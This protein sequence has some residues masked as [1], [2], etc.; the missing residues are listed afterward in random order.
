MYFYYITYLSGYVAYV[1]SIAVSLETDSTD[2][3]EA[4]VV[5]GLVEYGA[6]PSPTTGGPADV[7][8]AAPTAS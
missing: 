5:A 1:G 4:A 7:E 8:G 6:T 3:K 2:G